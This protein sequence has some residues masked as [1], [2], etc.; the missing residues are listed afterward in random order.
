MTRLFGFL[1]HSFTCRF[2]E[3]VS[4]RRRW[5]EGMLQYGKLHSHRG[6]WLLRRWRRLLYKPSM[7]STTVASSSERGRVEDVGFILPEHIHT[8][9]DDYYI[10][11]MNIHL[12]PSAA[13]RNYHH[14][15][16][17]E[18]HVPTE[19]R[20]CEGGWMAGFKWRFPVGAFSVSDRR[21]H[22]WSER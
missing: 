4:R 6:C 2:W 12:I 21:V 3:L 18:E 7:L 5:D 19:T 14:H 22:N 17:D 1:R 11:R 20:P 13:I 8:K 10:K 16:H 15:R 9:F